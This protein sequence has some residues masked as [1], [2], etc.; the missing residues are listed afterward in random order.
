MTTLMG[1][2]R[3]T[4]QQQR[5]VTTCGH[6]VLVTAAAGSG[7]TAVV[8][9]RCAYLVA[10]APGERRANVDELLVLTF[11]DAAAAEMRGRIVEAIQ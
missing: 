7:K 5:A 10:D 1:G 11:T 8:A 4:P 9:E 2:I 3:L 6:S